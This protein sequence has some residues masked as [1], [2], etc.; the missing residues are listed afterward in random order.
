MI[1][2]LWGAC[3]SL[4]FVVTA[5]I[6]TEAQQLVAESQVPGM[7]IEIRDLKRDEGGTLT[8]RFQLTNEKDTEV[9]LRQFAGESSDWGSDYTYVSGMYLLDMT[10]KKKYLVVRDSGKKCICSLLSYGSIGA[11][12]K[13]NLWAKFPAPPENVR[14]VSVMFPNFEPVDVPIAP[15]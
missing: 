7:K 14:K 12:S 10:N 9:P 15:R 6:A 11:G 8:L 3:L 5:P 4:A 2:N 1:R 13:V